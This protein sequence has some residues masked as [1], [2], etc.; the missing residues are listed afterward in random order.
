MEIPIKPHVRIVEFKVDADAAIG[1]RN[2][3]Y[4][5]ATIKA[6][7]GTDA[8]LSTISRAIE[9]AKASSHE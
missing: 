1:L 5:L 4:S 3:G 9:R 2:Q 8:S 6:R 7:L